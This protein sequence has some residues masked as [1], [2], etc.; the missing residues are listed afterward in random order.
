VGTGGKARIGRVV[1]LKRRRGLDGNP[2]RWKKKKPYSR[3]IATWRRGGDEVL[4][5]LFERAKSYPA[6]AKNLQEEQRR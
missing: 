1:Q 3:T 2:G 4:R 6:S 5:K